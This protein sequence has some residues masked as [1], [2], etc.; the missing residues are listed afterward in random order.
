MAIDTKHTMGDWEFEKPL[1][2]GASF[3]EEGQLVIRSFNAT[4]GEEEATVGSAGAGQVLLGFAKLDTV[5]PAATEVLAETSE[6]PAVPDVAGDYHVTLTKGNI[7]SDID[8]NGDVAV[9]D[10]T[11]STW[12]S[13]AAA[14]ASGD[15]I[16]SDAAN[17]ELEFHVDEAGIEIQVYYRRTLSASDRDQKYQQR[18]INSNAMA[19][20]EK[21]GVIS[22]VG[23]I[24]TDQY[25]VSVG[26]WST[27]TLRTGAAGV[28]TTA[29]GG[30]DISAYVR[31]V[32]APS[33]DD[34]MLELEFNLPMS[35]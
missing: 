32:K 16:V 31:V 22:G 7:T 4:T 20:L 14:I 27:G 19:S 13:V 1:A 26:D 23:R 21:I 5:S 33:V 11:N 12:L 30:T 8:A 10:V 35:S 2:T 25:D 9:Y 29:A 17:G 18:H 6:V 15:F 34:P 3:V 24:R 28:I